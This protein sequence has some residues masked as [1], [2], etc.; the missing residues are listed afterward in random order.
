MPRTALSKSARH[1]DKQ[2]LILIILGL[3]ALA[4]VFLLPL[5]ETG[6]WIV[7]NDD[8]ETITP[9]VL[10][11]TVNPSTAAELTRY[12]QESQTVLAQ[13]I[14]IRD[15][16]QSQNVDMWAAVEFQQTM[17]EIET[18]DQQY[19]FGE[20]KASLDNYQ[21]ALNGISK[22]EELGRQTLAT[23]LSDGL[24]AI[25]SLNV[26]VASTSSE[27][28]SAIAPDDQAVKVLSARL[29]TLPQVVRQLELGDEA[30]NRKDLDTAQTAYQNAVELDPL[31]S[32]ASESLSSIKTE[33]TDRAFRRQM[34]RGFAALENND[35]DQA[36]NAFRQANSVYPGHAAVAS[37]MT[38][39]GN[40]QSQ[41]RVSQEIQRAVELES[42]EEWQQ[43]LEV[44]ESLLRQDPS[45][46]EVKAKLIPVKVRADL[47]REMEDLIDD[48]LKLSNPVEYRR[49]QTVLNNARSIPNPEQR[50]HNQIAA[51]ESLL[52]T[53][54]STVEVVFQS[55]NQTNV[56]LFRVAE[57]GRFEQTSLKLK[58]GRYVAAGNRKGFRDVRVEFTITGT[59]ADKPIVVRCEESI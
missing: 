23:A 45:L 25:E 43:S 13:I 6:P 55:D 37:A 12:R 28:A 46:T 21:Q 53:A 27:L 49:A 2:K 8:M 29:E 41:R 11:T 38:Q 10:P 16:L 22:L 44:Y 36:Q 7:G 17:R 1:S 20:Y 26:A 56:T 5:L 52:V 35:F 42:R 48:P 30:R 32:R 59:P 19:N 39:V 57:L 54:V 33:I 58:P 51:L 18:G 40:R 3:L 24:Q 9:E 47:D 31:H 50:L 34:S 4:S 14:P 15:R